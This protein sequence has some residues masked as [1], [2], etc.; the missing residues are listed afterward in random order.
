MNN[1]RIE[2]AKQF[3]HE[4]H[5]SIG[6]VRKYSGQP[7][8]TH[9]DKVAGIVAS[10]GGTEDMIIAAHLHD[11]VEDVNK[12][13]YT[14]EGIRAR[15]GDN[16]ARLVGMLT[17]VFTKES[18]PSLNRKARKELERARIAET[19][20]EAKTIKLADLLDN[21]ASITEHD[22]DFAVV[23]LREK[24]EL[25]PLLSEG[26]PELL[27]RAAMQAVA[28]CAALGVDIPMLTSPTN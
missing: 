27:N 24:L 7:Y 22:K 1:E 16:V 12:G 14:L 2:A 21:T 26:N 6:Q 8:W 17:D 4:A 10:V 3:S 5:D 15:F 20:V 18:F 19:T 23:Y 25:L 28:A 11:V 13:D 9:T